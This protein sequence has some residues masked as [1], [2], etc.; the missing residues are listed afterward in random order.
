MHGLQARDQVMNIGLRL[1]P[2]I[3]NQYVKQRIFKRYYTTV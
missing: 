1:Q 3:K 2:Q